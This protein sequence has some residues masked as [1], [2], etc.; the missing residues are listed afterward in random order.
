MDV[1]C[2]SSR[3]GLAPEQRSVM[4][5]VLRWL[6]RNGPSVLHE[7]HCVG[8]D[9]TLATMAQTMGYRVIAHPPTVTDWISDF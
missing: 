8:G 5:L 9:L 1:G 2:T 7:G 4:Q 3:Y 6:R